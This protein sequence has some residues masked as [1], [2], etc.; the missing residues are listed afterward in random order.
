M[1]DRIVL[2]QAESSC[3]IES[4]SHP[5]LP[6]FSV[7]PTNI[8][9]E[10]EYSRFLHEVLPPPVPHFSLHHPTTPRTIRPASASHFRPIKKPEG[11][12]CPH[13]GSNDLWSVYY[14]EIKNPPFFY[15]KPPQRSVRAVVVG[16]PPTHPPLRS[17]ELDTRYTQYVRCPGNI[18][19]SFV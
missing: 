7:L 8:V 18:R 17:V 6:G 14:Y 16:V 10:T 19:Q 5:L 4:S 1:F 13:P 15:V 12:L 2:K 11:S 3:N 9:L